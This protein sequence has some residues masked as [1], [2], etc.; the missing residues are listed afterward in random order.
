MQEPSPAH[1][2]RVWCSEAHVRAF[3][4]AEGLSTA[5]GEDTSFPQPQ[6]CGD[7]QLCLPQAFLCCPQSFINVMMTHSR[8]IYV[9]LCKV[10]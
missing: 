4:A 6:P 8:V 10:L 7:G 3:T 9:A 5:N 2:L 1:F